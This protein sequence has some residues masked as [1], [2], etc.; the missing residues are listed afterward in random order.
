MF[1]FRSPSSLSAWYS[2]HYSH[3]DPMFI[4]SEPTRQSGR[5]SRSR[6]ENHCGTS[7]ANNSAAKLGPSPPGTSYSDTDG[8]RLRPPLYGCG[9]DD[10]KMIGPISLT[11]MLSRKL[12]GTSSCMSPE[13]DVIRILV[14]SCSLAHPSACASVRVP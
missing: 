1:T 12:Y 14:L 13:F 2:Q 5:G 8:R 6:N 10:C 11:H 4:F 9:W 3:D 7:C